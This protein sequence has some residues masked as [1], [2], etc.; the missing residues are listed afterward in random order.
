M[1]KSPTSVRNKALETTGQMGKSSKHA[2]MFACSAL[3]FRGI[4]PCLLYSVC[5]SI[6]VRYRTVHVRFNVVTAHH[7]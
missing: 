3:V 1:E 6:G 7:Y 4:F 5:V 2:C